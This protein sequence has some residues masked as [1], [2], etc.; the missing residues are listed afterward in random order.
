MNFYIYHL[1]SLKILSKKNGLKTKTEAFVDRNYNNDFS[2]VSRKEKNAVIE[3]ENIAVKHLLR[4]INEQKIVT[5]RY[6]IKNLIADTYCVHGDNPNAIK[7]LKLI[8]KEL[9]NNNIIIG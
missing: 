7:I 1:Q 2:L 9:T 8:S 6:E 3:D 5:N 4:M